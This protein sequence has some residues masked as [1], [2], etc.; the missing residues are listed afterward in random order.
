M[1]NRCLATGMKLSSM[2]PSNTNHRARRLPDDGVSDHLQTPKNAGLRLASDHQQIRLQFPG[3]MGDNLRNVSSLYLY[4]RSR[5]GRL[6]QSIERAQGLAARML[7]PALGDMQESQLRLIFLGQ[8]AGPAEHTGARW[9]QVHGAQQIRLQF[10][11][12]MGDNL[13]NVSS[14]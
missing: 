6:L 14:L 2:H 1:P 7:S 5:T 9:L 11:G 3:Q 8:M 4:G 12:Q 13:R 10:P